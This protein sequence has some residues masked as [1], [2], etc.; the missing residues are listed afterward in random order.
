VRAGVGARR[1]LAPASQGE[2]PGPC[3]RSGGGGILRGMATRLDGYEAIAFAER[4]G[5]LLSLHAEGDEPA[6]DDV[7]LDEARRIAAAAP[8]RVFVDFDELDPGGAIG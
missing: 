6:R 2:G 8:Q 5:C 7:M 3:C 4:S 1:A